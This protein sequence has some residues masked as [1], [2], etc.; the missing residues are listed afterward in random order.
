MI[1][2]E[3]TQILPHRIYSAFVELRTRLWGGETSIK[4]PTNECEIL[5][6]SVMGYT[7]SL[8]QAAQR[9]VMSMGSRLI[10]MD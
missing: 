1:K 2:G 3:R 10:A 8:S 5:N 6:N 9:V 7:E 4:N